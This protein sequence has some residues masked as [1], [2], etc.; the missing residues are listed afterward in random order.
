[1]NDYDV[2]YTLFQS[3]WEISFHVGHELRIAIQYTT[4]QKCWFGSLLRPFSISFLSSHE[5][6]LS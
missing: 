3:V 5:D 2:Q 1:M 6:G 4:V